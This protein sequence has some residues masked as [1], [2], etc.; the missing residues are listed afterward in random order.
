MENVT[1]KA[2]RQTNKGALVFDVE[3]R[4]G[5]H[6]AGISIQRDYKPADSESYKTIDIAQI[7]GFDMVI[8]LSGVRLFKRDD[9]THFISHDVQLSPGERNQVCNAVIDFINEG[10]LQKKTIDASMI[11]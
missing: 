10:G 6:S 3:I 5:E 1:V 9:G 8:N 4:K 2:G 7:S 11:A